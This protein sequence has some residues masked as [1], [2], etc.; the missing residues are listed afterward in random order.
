MKTR[1]SI[2]LVEDNED[3]SALILR[4]LKK[5]KISFELEQ[6]DTE[7]DFLEK[8]SARHYDI[9]LSDFNLPQFSGAQ[10]LELL[11]REKPEIPFL[12]VSGAVGEETAVEMLKAGCVDF[13]MKNNLSRLPSAVLRAIRE[14]QSQKEKAEALGALRESELRFRRIADNSPSLIWMT[15]EQNECVYVNKLWLHITGMTED[16]VLGAGWE[17]AVFPDDLVL[18]KKEMQRAVEKRKPYDAEYRLMHADG[19]IRWVLE[20]GTPNILA[21]NEFVGYIG[22]CIDITERKKMQH[23]VRQT[24]ELLDTFFQQSLDGCYFIMLKEPMDWFL[25][26][27]KKRAVDEILRTGTVT[28][29]N[30]AVT[31]QYKS[32]NSR[33]IGTYLQS[34][35]RCDNRE[36][37]DNF[38][39]NLFSGG[40]TGYS[41]T[42]TIKNNLKIIVEG[43][44]VCLYDE[45]GKI[46]GFFGIQRDITTR[47]KEQGELE[48]NKER[49]LKFFGEDIKGDFIITPEGTLELC[50]DSFLSILRYAHRDELQGMNFKKFFLHESE[51]PAFIEKI[52]RQ[53]KMETFEVQFQKKDGKEFTAG[54]TAAGY[55][56]SS[57]E[58]IEIIG[59][60]QDESQR[61]EIENHMVQAQ[62][63]ES[64]G[65]LASG[66]A[67][68]F[69]NVLNNIFGFSQQ[70]MKYYKDT[71][72]VLRYAETISRSA[73]R[74]MDLSMQLLSFA[75]QRKVEFATVDLK[76]IVNE[77]VTM[78]RNTFMQTVNISTVIDDDLWKINGDQGAVYQL[79]LNMCMNSRDAIVERF[80][81]V[82]GQLTVEVRNMLV[83]ND[84]MQ[85]FGDTPTHSVEI[86]LRD[87]G[88]GMPPE[89]RERIFDPFFTT[90]T[91]IK[92]RGS[93][94]GMT[95]VYNVIKSHKGA[96]TVNTKPENG[97]EFRIYFPA[98]D[99]SVK[100][101]PAESENK[102]HSRR[103][104]LVLL[105]DDETAMREL[106]KELLEEA[107]YRVKLASS[108]PEAVEI[109]KAEADKIDLVVLDIVM[110]DM[111]GG[112]TFLELKKIKNKFPVFFC[113]GYVS[114]DLITS[115]L[116]EENLK[117]LQKPFRAEQFLQFVYET[118]GR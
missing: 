35:F 92:N 88:C 13:I 105:V 52:K 12:L 54:I 25:Q 98:V 50:N 86:I 83:T 90:K 7:K 57:G 93:G 82:P 11:K 47:M 91:D 107:G 34:F 74:G 49:F 10:A 1:T 101:L 60:L 79:L 53:K 118:L 51:F 44:A 40:A 67:H 63:L 5:E 17:K 16:K 26:R 100:E 61:E 85:W 23:M 106:G 19:S 103:N 68:D 80:K 29:V 89:V 18:W 62:K 58:M 21:D 81:N 109:F 28:M 41:L 27:D 39:S 64:I 30:N 46:T 96:I 59:S 102:Y 3:D 117:A 116:Q 84:A 55:F 71:A 76:S 38:L 114:E 73:E 75:R 36:E 20:R 115:L 70:L 15:N 24:T 94:L 108:G 77:V 43:N 4:E 48:K 56:S 113:S 66:V 111:D 87:N 112:Q 8:I 14:A 97:T 99:Y 72:R 45:Q 104:E 78:C 9:I 95:V 37:L 31:H 22:S 6:V 110:P 33:I 42:V 69:N 32:Q 65:T 2:L